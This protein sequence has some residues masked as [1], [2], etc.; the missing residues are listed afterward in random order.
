MSEL[1]SAAEEL[2]N[3]RYNPAHNSISKV[4]PN[5]NL[6][7]G[8]DHW[9]FK[10]WNPQF[11]NISRYCLKDSVGSGRYS[12]V[13][14]GLQDNSN[15]CAIKILKPVNI[16]RVRREVKAIT[17]LQGHRNI[18]KL[19]DVVFE[20]VSGIVSIVTNYV[21]NTPWKT[22]YS[23]MSLTDARLYMFKVLNV[24]HYSHSHGI[25]HRDIKPMN[26][27]CDSPNKDLYVGDWGL[28]EFYHPLRKY[29]PKIA[30]RYYKSPE[31][32]L[33]Y[34][35]YD[36]SVDIW[37]AGVTFLELVSLK[38]HAFDSRN[39]DN[40]ILS[41]ASIF[42]GEKIVKSAKKYNV[43]LPPSLESVLVSTLPTGLETLFVNSRREFREEKLLDL[44]S[45]MLEIDHRDRITAE[46]A[47]NHS[48]FDPIRE[49]NQDFEY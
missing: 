30:T 19:I 21:Q 11:G 31:L 29:T 26:I 1:S 36:Y 47:L 4:F 41:I 22:L 37:A 20:P 27:L 8:V 7:N 45:C 13:F 16:D 25:M 42:G 14:F 33:E 32:L 23:R 39:P 9:K 28:A 35:F 18:L 40:Q 12:E 46:Q 5:V 6:E 10:G 2:I 44:I 49:Q 48:F 38:F 43:L 17:V 3:G 15:E 24:I 34:G